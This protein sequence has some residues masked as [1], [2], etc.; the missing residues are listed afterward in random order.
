MAMRT[1]LELCADNKTV[2]I[3]F[4]EALAIAENEDAVAVSAIIVLANTG[5]PMLAFT[6]H[7]ELC[8]GAAHA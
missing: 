3:I 5:T 1:D 8:I 2:P 6:V 4:A 7:F